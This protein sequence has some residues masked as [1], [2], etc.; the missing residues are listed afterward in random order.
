MKRLFALLCCILLLA[1]SLTPA[2]GE[3]TDTIIEPTLP[4]DAEPYDPEHPEILEDD[5]LYATSAILVEANT[6]LVIYE[7]NADMIMYPASTTKILTVLLGLILSEDPSEIVT[8]SETAMNIP[9]DSST[10]KLQAGEQISLLDVMYGTIMLSANEG[11]NVIAESVC[12]D[13]GSFVDQMNTY[14]SMLGCTSTHF[15]NPH[16]YH[17]NDHY[18]TARDL[19]TIAREATKNETFREIVG[20]INHV[21]PRNNVHRERTITTRSTLL[22]P[23]TEESP[24]RYYY[25]YATGIKSGSHSKAGYAFVGSA[26]RDGVDLIS[27]VLYTSNRG[28][29]TDTKKLM[30]YGFSQYVS[31]SP[32]DLYNMNPVRINATNYSMQDKRMGEMELTCV[33]LDAAGSTVRITATADEV[34]YMSSNLRSTVLIDYT[35]DFVAPIEAG[36]QIGTMTY[37]TDDGQPVVYALLASRSVARRENAPPSIAEIYAV[38]DADPN[39]LPPLNL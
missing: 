18:T 29:W 26:S 9:A 4:P 37:F 17:D 36:E 27:V 6:G 11:A 5:M 34:A 39:P 2:L 15:A 23:P 21:I 1:S 25:E 10:M 24:N 13:I 14:A 7:K 33:A 20:A 31:V 30:E 16:G 19:A 22:I 35:R 32:I 38:A 28:R 3:E 8:V 12:G